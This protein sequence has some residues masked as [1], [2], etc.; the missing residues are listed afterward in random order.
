MG[1]RPPPPPPAAAASG[2]GRLAELSRRVPIVMYGAQWCGACRQAR[3]WLRQE[4]VHYVDHDIDREPA[5]RSRLRAIA[6]SGG[7]PTF[8]IDGAVSTGFSASRVRAA[9][10]RAARRR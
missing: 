7:I 3:A 1:S 6:P 5:A 10:E 4:G 2:G 8:E 9:V